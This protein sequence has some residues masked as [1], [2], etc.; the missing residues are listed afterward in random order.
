MGTKIKTQ[1]KLLFNSVAGVWSFCK[2]PK[3]ASP[4]SVRVQ[5]WQKP[6][7]LCFACRFCENLGSEEQRDGKAQGKSGLVKVIEQLFIIFAD[8]KEQEQEQEQEQG[9][10]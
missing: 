2:K 6:A 10:G 7:D 5:G 8:E 3:W 1:R 4:L 9:E